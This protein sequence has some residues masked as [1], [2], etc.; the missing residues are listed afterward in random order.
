M[1][2]FREEM[3]ALVSLEKTFVVEIEVFE[4][5]WRCESPCVDSDTHEDLVSVIRNLGFPAKRARE[6]IERVVEKL[7][8]E[9]E[10]LSEEKILTTALRSGSSVRS[11]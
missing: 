5:T 11:R 8:S 3:K 6:R 7:E 9:G 10:Q 2:D 1:E 4:N